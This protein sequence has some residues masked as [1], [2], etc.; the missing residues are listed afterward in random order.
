VVVD[1]ASRMAGNLTPELIDGEMLDVE[2]SHRRLGQTGEEE[3]LR[4]LERKT[5][6]LL[7]YAAAAGACIGCG[8]TWTDCPQARDLD[9]FGRACGIAFQL[10]DDILGLVGDERSLGKPIGSDLREGKATVPLLHALRHAG[11]EQR[12]TF[13]RTIGNP[14]APAGD[15]AATTALIRELGGIAHAQRLAKTYLEAAQHHLEPIPESPAKA[16]IQAWAEFLFN[17][18]S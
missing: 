7:G 11:P 1:L 16:W 18:I 10:Q 4:M 6:A 13:E 14:Q 9:G 17:R 3:I 8:K 2:F 5:G 12:R 15:L